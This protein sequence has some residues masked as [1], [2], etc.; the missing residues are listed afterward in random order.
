MKNITSVSLKKSLVNI[1][2]FSFVKNSVDK[3]LINRYPNIT[4]F[5]S[6][7]RILE[8]GFTQLFITV[9]ISK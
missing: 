6:F 3:V 8:E 4:Y 7:M 9:N 2:T 5:M 1:D